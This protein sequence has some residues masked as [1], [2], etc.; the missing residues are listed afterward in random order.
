MELEKELTGPDFKRWAD[1]TGIDRK[2]MAD[3]LE[4]SVSALHD[5]FRVARFKRFVAMGIRYYA[6][7]VAE[8]KKK[9]GAQA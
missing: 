5:W 9:E 7:R 2:V 1:G 6:K 8:A 3:H 4:I